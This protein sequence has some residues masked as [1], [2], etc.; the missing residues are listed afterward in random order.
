MDEKVM[1]Y[2]KKHR[3]CKY[4][5]HKILNPSM[6]GLTPE[7]YS[8]QAKDKILSDW[9]TEHLPKIFCS[10]YRVKKY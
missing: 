3:R 10:C 9:S 1:K 4:C 7:F 6:M 5:L 2:R 8:C